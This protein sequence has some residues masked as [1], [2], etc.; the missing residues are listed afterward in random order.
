MIVCILIMCREIW[1]FKNRN[2]NEISQV[3]KDFNLLLM[4][5]IVFSQLLSL[6]LNPVSFLL[7]LP[8][9]YCFLKTCKNYLCICSEFLARGFFHSNNSLFLLS[10]NSNCKPGHSDCISVMRHLRLVGLHQAH[11]LGIS[12]QVAGA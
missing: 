5:F 8:L 10:N 6:P 4:S 3:Y 12:N 1:N 11:L 9:R 7:K 2:D